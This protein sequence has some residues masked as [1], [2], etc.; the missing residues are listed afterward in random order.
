ML[1]AT[2]AVLLAQRYFRF[3]FGI[4]FRLL[5]GNVLRSGPMHDARSG[6]KDCRLDH[7]SQVSHPA[8]ARSRASAQSI[9]CLLYTSDA[10]DE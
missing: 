9:P 8:M 4:Y 5:F 10:A 6:T 7:P 2:K 3:M 1:P